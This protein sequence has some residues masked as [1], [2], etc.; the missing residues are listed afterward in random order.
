MREY[1]KYTSYR[2]GKV[3]NHTL[4]FSPVSRVARLLKRNFPHSQGSTTTHYSCT[5]TSPSRQPVYMIPKH[6]TESNAMTG[7]I[8][9]LELGVQGL[10]DHLLCLHDGRSHSGRLPLRGQ[11]SIT[12]SRLRRQAVS[13]DCKVDHDLTCSQNTIGASLSVWCKSC[14]WLISPRT[15]LSHF[16]HA[17]KRYACC[18][19]LVEQDYNYLNAPGMQ[20]FQLMF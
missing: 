5:N 3:R 8:A 4:P 19:W 15:F 9:C 1:L 14:R 7:K 13:E 17:G 11:R 6:R 16:Y 2:Y 20:S 18:L 12:I 10:H